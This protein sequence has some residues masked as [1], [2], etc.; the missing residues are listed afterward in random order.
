MCVHVC[1]CAYV[2]VCM[3]SDI[4]DD[5]GQ[6]ILRKRAKPYLAYSLIIDQ[7]VPCC[8]VSVDIFLEGKIHQAKCNLSCVAQ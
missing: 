5:R 2:C 3:C 8:Y 1:V 4:M 7:Y 6:S